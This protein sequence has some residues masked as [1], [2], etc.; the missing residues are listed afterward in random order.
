M[1]KLSGITFPA[2]GKSVFKEDWEREQVAKAQEVIDRDLDLHGSGIVSGGAIAAGASPN[3]IDLT[4]TVIAYNAAGQR[5]VVDPA[6]TGIAVPADATSKIVLRHAFEETENT[7]PNNPG[8]PIIWRD[9]SYEIVARQGDLQDG[10]VPLRE[11]TASGGTV[12]PGTDLRQRKGISGEHIQ[13]ETLDADH[14]PDEEL[15]DSKLLP[16][17]KIGD[18]ADLLAEIDAGISAPKSI[19]KALNWIHL[20]RHD[21][22]DLKSMYYYKAPSAAHPW[23]CLNAADQVIMESAWPDLVAYLRA[24]P[25]RYLATGSNKSAFDIA[26][27]SI[28][29][30]VVTLTLTNTTAENAFLA[31]L[32]EER[33]VHG[34]YSNFP[35][36]RLNEAVGSVPVGDYTPTEVDAV[37]RLI[38][39]A[40]TTANDS[41]SPGGKTV[42]C[43]KHRVPGF[44]DRAYHYAVQG[45]VL[46]AAEDSDHEV[47]G[48]GRRR[49]RFQGHYHTLSN[50]TAV[51]RQPG[52][53]GFGGMPPDSS[54]ATYALTVAAP[55][56]DG[57][58][59]TPRTGKT[60]DPRAQ[61]VYLYKY[62]RIFNA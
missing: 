44:T 39:F 61:G 47:F 10:D 1:D 60:T 59:G 13:L 54:N 55:I 2:H 33:Q 34:S 56:T 17:H 27:F 45:R 20:N 35:S 53:G 62:G 12:T 6:P 19:I 51:W 50:G 28:T 23:F 46:V 38:R 52:S 18:L 5:I 49:D 16:A 3:T 30:N 32:L 7:A 40:Y 36:I 43:Y 11:V 9:N 26:S 41:G 31:A 58:N 8:D 48:G 22:G 37:S 57:T 4:E 42:S 24:E 29:S 15:P 21:V 25:W 14:F